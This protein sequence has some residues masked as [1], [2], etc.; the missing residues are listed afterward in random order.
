[1]WGFRY[2]WTNVG[3]EKRVDRHVGHRFFVYLSNFYAPLDTVFY[4][5]PLPL[6][7]HGG[8]LGLRYGQLF[9]IALILLL[10]WLNYYGVKL[11]GDVQVTVTVVKVA[12]I[13]MIIFSGLVLGHAHP[14]SAG[15]PGQGA[16]RP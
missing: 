2:S 13:A 3:R 14:P 11:G 15:P 16:P 7:P 4:S 12:L 5:L 8:P 1:M 6:G 9:A 10:G